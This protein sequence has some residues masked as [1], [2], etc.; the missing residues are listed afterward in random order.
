MRCSSLSGSK[1]AIQSKQVMMVVGEAS[2]D[3]HGAHLV[4]ALSRRDQTLRFFGVAGEQ[5]KQTTFEAAF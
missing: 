1:M 4:R 5:L 3:V 2:G